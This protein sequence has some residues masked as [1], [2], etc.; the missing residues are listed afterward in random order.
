MT[1]HAE[2]VDFCSRVS[3][4]VPVFIDE[5]YL[6]FLEDSEKKSMVTLINQGKDVIIARTFSKIFGL[7]GLRIGYVVAQQATLEKMQ[8]ITRGGMGISFP[9]IFAASASMDDEPFQVTS[10]KRNLAC[11]E[12]VYEHLTRMGYDYVPSSTSFILFPIEMEGKSFL[13]KM[14]NQQVMVRAFEIHKRNWCRV[15]MGTMDE[16]NVFVNALNKV[17]G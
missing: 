8:K 3:D 10:R 9:S 1:D 12:F 14:R 6:D 11:R 5:A 17:V 16:M 7:A 2:L 13:E 15:S 4:R